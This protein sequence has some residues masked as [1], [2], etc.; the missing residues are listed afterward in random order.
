M[1]LIS[2][3][4]P[5]TKFALGIR[6]NARESTIDITIGEPPGKAQKQRAGGESTLIVELL[7]APAPASGALI[8][9]LTPQ[10][11]ANKLGLQPGD[12][13]ESINRIPVRSTAQF[14]TQQQGISSGT[15]QLW[16]VRRGDRLFFVAVKESVERL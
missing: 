1:Q 6:R 11:V 2:Q 16:G 7:P 12:I 10:S 5:E 15:A 14:W 3:A 9:S 8:S 13:I 4:E